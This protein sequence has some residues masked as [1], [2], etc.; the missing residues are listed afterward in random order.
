M[1]F[2]YNKVLKGYEDPLASQIGLMSFEI[3]SFLLLMVSTISNNIFNQH[4]FGNKIFTNT[5]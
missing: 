4:E 2:C 5:T 3:A 1:T